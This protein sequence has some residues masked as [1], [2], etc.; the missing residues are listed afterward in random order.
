[1]PFGKDLSHLIEEQINR[2]VAGNANAADLVNT[3][4]G[5]INEGRIALL[6]ANLQRL[7]EKFHAFTAAQKKSKRNIVD[8][9]LKVIAL[10]GMRLAITAGRATF[11]ELEAPLDLPYTFVQLTAAGDTR[12]IR[13]IYLTKDGSIIESSTD[14]TNIGPDYISLAL[15]DIWSGVS[16]ISQDK[17]I[18]IRPQYGDDKTN[19][20]QTEITGNATLYCPDTGN[21]SFVVTAT[22]PA[23]LA[24]DVSS[25][26]ALVEGE[27]INAEGGILDLTN[28]RTIVREFL[29]ISD[30]SST[31]YDLYHKSVANVIVY[32]DDEI[33][34]PIIDSENGSVGFSTA[35]PS[36]AKIFASY[37]FGGNYMLV[38]VV[39]K[40]QT[41]DGKAMGVIGWQLGSNRHNYQPP[42]LPAYQ[43]AIAK[44]DMSATISVI[45]DEI[46]D[47]SFEV[48]NLTQ[49]E[50]QYG[51]NL[52][53]SSLKAGAV[54]AA[55]IAAGSIDAAK[56]IAGAIQSDHIAAGA[57][58]TSHIATD[59]ITAE[60]IRGGTITADKF[61]DTTWGDMSQALRFV[62]SILGGEQ[63]W[64]RTITK[65][66]LAVGDIENVAVS[67]RSFPSLR[68]DTQ[69][70]W[71]GAQLTWDSAL[72]W[73]IPV[74]ATGFWESASIDFG[75]ISN[76]QAEF[77]AQVLLDDPAVTVTVKAKYSDDDISWTDYEIMSKNVSFGYS[78]WIGSLQA[79]R[80]FKIRVE[81]TT[82]N[83]SKYTL[84]GYPEVRLAN[85][86]IGTEDI[87]EQAITDTKLA[88]G[89]VTPIKLSAG[90]LANNI[91]VMTGSISNGGIIP[92]PT[93]YSQEQCRWMVS[94]R[95]MYFAG[96]VD[97][98]DSEYCYADSNRVVSVYGNEQRAPFVANYIII[99]IK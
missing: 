49:E 43:H 37:T 41:A 42:E 27:I 23:G 56:I 65:T 5:G 32:V 85:C 36:G 83:E 98:N 24:V 13:Y 14:P 44:V 33:V 38:F 79:F 21:D 12:E 6:E 10:H 29:G 50:L 46:I 22:S 80:F 89:A 15:I 69:N 16:E 48:K 19:S 77:W 90:A 99:G 11:V 53:S 1:M 2:T 52:G 84:L 71:D 51:E 26:R 25:G 4:L 61:E 96:D 55:K 40:T 30:G 9:G 91:V 66:D 88:N 94:F 39:E 81:F 31:N 68:L 63:S 62:K 87:A 8:Y 7:A 59:S 47:N 34:S 60:M 54:T 92:L 58:N 57:I 86:Q 20:E 73:D 75:V 3:A 45:A 18:D 97:G 17:I 67:T 35:P 72:A 28:H 95:E 93:G 70:H 76:L 82:T 64:R 74:A 78:F